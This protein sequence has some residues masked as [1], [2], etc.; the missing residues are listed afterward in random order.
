MIQIEFAFVTAVCVAMEMLKTINILTTVKLK[1]Y[2][3]T[4]LVEKLP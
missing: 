2:A 4:E 3:I 1:K